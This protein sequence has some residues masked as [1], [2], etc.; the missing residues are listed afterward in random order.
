MAQ[1]D[2]TDDF[3]ANVLGQRGRHNNVGDVPTPQKRKKTW[4]FVSIA[5]VMIV[6]SAG[7]AGYLLTRKEK[8]LD[9]VSNTVLGE[10]SEKVSFPIYY[11]DTSKLPDGYTF[12]EASITNPQP[13]AILYKV[14]Y[15]NGAKEVIFSLQPKISDDEMRKFYN[16]FIPVRYE[17]DTP[18]GIADIGA[19]N[20]GPLIQNLAS[21]PVKD[22]ATWLIVTAPSDINEDQFAL[23]LKSLKK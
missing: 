10:Y 18:I 21:L 14:L 12:D 20:N 17:V 2:E 15:E 19:Y 13:E 5:A 7:G 6:M 23:I 22:D 11:P 3:L 1:H 8:A 16:N 4:L 9:E